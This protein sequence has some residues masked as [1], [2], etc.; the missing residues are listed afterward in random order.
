MTVM[1]MMVVLP[2]MDK[3][4]TIGKTLTSELIALLHFIVIIDLK[5]AII[6]V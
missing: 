6:V 2:S 1:T 3:I 5:M 4:A